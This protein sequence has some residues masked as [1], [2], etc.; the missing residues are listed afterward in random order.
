MNTVS[1]YFDKDF[2]FTTENTGKNIRQLYAMN[3]VKVFQIENVSA[4]RAK[5]NV[6]NHLKG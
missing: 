1:L 5:E 3:K 6:F 2:R 4:C